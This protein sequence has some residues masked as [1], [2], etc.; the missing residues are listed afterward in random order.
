MS[1][2]LCVCRL[3]E[4]EESERD[5]EGEHTKKKLLK[6]EEKCQTENEGDKDASLP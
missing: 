4:I 3:P 2:C 5:N 1:T 6:K